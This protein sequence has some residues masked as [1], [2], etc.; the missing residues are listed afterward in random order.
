VKGI[1]P[2]SLVA[3]IGAQIILGNAY[4]LYLR[5]GAE[6][7]ER[8]GGL[9]RFMQWDG[10]IL[11]DSG[12]YQVFSLAQR[13]SISE[14]GVRFQS[15]LDGSGHD[16]T[17]E[18]VVDIQRCIGSDIMM[19]LD[20]CPPG[21][22]TE[23]YARQSSELT[24]RWASRSKDR[25][26]ATSRGCEHDQA[27]FAIVQG[28]GYPSIRR[29]SAR[30][31]IDIGFPGYAIGGLSVGEP[32]EVMYDMVEVSCEV[33]PT[34]SPRYLM[35]V[36]TPANLI[37]NIDRGIDMFDCVLPTRN[38]RNGMLFTTEGILNIRNQKWTDDFSVI[39]PG[40]VGYASQTF[41]K[42]YLR[43]LLQANEILGLLIAST[44][45]LSFY[46]WLMA[47]ARRAITE[48]RFGAWKR[49]MLPLVSRRL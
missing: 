43:H 14:H 11:T 27:L 10:P 44:Q 7:I 3:D 46:V 33:L 38:G 19:V 45:N 26:D 31:L 21:D 2:R 17:P 42:S 34:D 1:S 25:F 32:S 9:H 5:P 35:G 6:L 20:E 39:D 47:E 36:G 29:D 18:S 37:E 15:H 8:A 49:E 41:T 23:T 4:H 30:A 24:V 16:F 40:I 28:V 12:G 22:A 13:R 48:A